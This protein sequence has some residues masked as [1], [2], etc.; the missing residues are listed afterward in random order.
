[1]S[2][3]AHCSE[4]CEIERIKRDLMV[5][6]NSEVSVFC[7]I[8]SFIT[9]NNQ[10]HPKAPHGDD[11]DDDLICM[12]EVAEPEETE[13]MEN[14]GHHTDDKFNVKQP[15]GRVLGLLIFNHRRKK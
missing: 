8:W 7:L 3:R 11:S 6:T 2:K 14:A 9:P 10:F 15:N 13:D 12:G 4:S 1:M 5:D